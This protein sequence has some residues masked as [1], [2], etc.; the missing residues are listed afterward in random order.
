MNPKKKIVVI[1]NG[2]IAAD[3]LKII[4]AAVE[5]RPWELAHVIADSSQNISTESV[6]KICRLRGVSCEV[7]KNVNAPEVLQRLEEISPEIIF[8]INNF[9]LLRAPLL[10]LAPRGVIN[11]HNGPLPR[12]AGSNICTWAVYAGETTHGVTWHV[13]DGGIDSGPIVAQKCFPIPADST[14][15]SLVMQCLVEGALL[16][17]SALPA[18]MDDSLV[19]LAQDP[20]QRTFYP[21]KAAPN[22]G[23]L[24]VDWNFEQIDRFVRSL[25]YHP[26]PSPLPLP[27]LLCE[28]QVLQI[29]QVSFVRAEKTGVCGEILALEKD[30]F[31]FQCGDSV[32]ALTKMRDASGKVLDPESWSAA[33]GI[34][35]GQFL[36]PS[37]L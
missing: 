19:P 29:D 17:E 6:E 23:V 35:V 27:A 32:V 26:F 9:Q 3:C 25:H 8:S 18:I 21:M 12:Y 37:S 20:Q 16:F 7:S 11:F 13:V 4:L 31:H 33:H 36:R 30:K 28:E 24:A 14:A 34:S 22:D 15:I 1:G 2:K 10:A 5:T